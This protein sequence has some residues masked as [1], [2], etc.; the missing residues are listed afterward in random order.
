MIK[1]TRQLN[2][3][4]EFT[5][6]NPTSEQ[7]KAVESSTIEPVAI[8]KNQLRFEGGVFKTRLSN[9]KPKLAE[10]E[11]FIFI[12]EIIQKEI[13]NLWI[14][15][16][17]AQTIEVQTRKGYPRVFILD[18]DAILRKTLSGSYF[19][20]APIHVLSTDRKKEWWVGLKKRVKPLDRQ[21]EIP[22]EKMPE[23][24]SRLRRYT[25]LP[26]NRTA[27]PETSPQTKD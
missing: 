27:T 9:L 25:K 5:P 1:E 17:E 23:V 14:V 7:S 10:S 21:R 15:E 6:V 20:R 22:Q 12:D 4:G 19:P 11:K 2:F 18:N 24:I 8:S 26:K 16:K 13:P 3:G